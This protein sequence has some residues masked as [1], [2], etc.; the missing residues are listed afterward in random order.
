[1]EQ[2]LGKKMVTDHG[3]P[4]ECSCYPCQQEYKKGMLPVTD[5]LLERAIN[6]SVGVVDKGLGAGFGIHPHST[7]KEIDQKAQEFISAVKESV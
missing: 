5:R 4:Y 1:M 7:D 6:I 2:I 3:C